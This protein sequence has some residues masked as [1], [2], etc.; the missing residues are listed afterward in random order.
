LGIRLGKYQ[1]VEQNVRIRSPKI[2]QRRRAIGE[3]DQRDAEKRI[4]AT[5]PEGRL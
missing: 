3:F 1:P 5:G 4:P 2:V